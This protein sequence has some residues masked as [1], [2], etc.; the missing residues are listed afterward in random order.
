[1]LGYESLTDA[2][3][4]AISSA[5]LRANTSSYG[6]VCVMPL[7]GLLLARRGRCLA[8]FLGVGAPSTDFADLVG[9]RNDGWRSLQSAAIGIGTDHIEIDCLHHFGKLFR[10]ALQPLSFP[11]STE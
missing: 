4:A 6:M 8:H 9:V 5:D 2:S 11:G 10:V 1:M 3:A 7:C